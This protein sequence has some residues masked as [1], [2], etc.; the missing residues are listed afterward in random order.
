MSD[1]IEQA[2]TRANEL[3]R[4]DDAHLF[5]ALA[6][7]IRELEAERDV[8]RQR[9]E[10]LASSTALANLRKMEASFNTIE[11]A[12]IERCAEVADKH[13]AR[14]VASQIR[15]LKPAAISP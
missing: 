8:I 1:L 2:D 9:V 3:R 5:R 6:A 13:W 12:T 11:A 14:E 7:R 4:G 15:A 10:E